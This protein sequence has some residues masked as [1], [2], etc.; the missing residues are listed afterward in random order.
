[1]KITDQDPERHNS[2]AY[3]MEVS[4]PK[5]ELVPVVS[6]KD[7]MVNAARMH[8]QQEYDRIMSL[9]AVL[10]AQADDIRRRLELTDRVAAARYNMVLYPGGR[11]WLVHDQ[12]RGDTLLTPLGPEEWSTGAPTHYEYLAHI[13]WLGDNTWREINTP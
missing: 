11:Y 5:F 3:P 9:V 6:H 8:A 13:E 4:A 10:Q 2:I 1:M 12:R 7:L